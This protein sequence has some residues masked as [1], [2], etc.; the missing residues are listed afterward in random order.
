MGITQLEILVVK[1]MMLRMTRIALIQILIFG[2]IR[3]IGGVFVP[4]FFNSFHFVR[5]HA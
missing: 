4:P 3:A 2:E 1:T 5:H